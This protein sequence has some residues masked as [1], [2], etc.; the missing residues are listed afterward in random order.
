MKR[1]VRNLLAAAFAK[2]PRRP[3]A[4]LAFASAAT[5]APAQT[6]TRWDGNGHS[7]GVFAVKAG[8][9][10]EWAKRD[11]ESRGGHLATLTSAAENTF[12]TDLADDPEY[13]ISQYGS[14]NFGP[15][16]G[17]SRPDSSSGVND[18]RWVTG[19][20]FGYS[21]WQPLSGEPNNSGGREIYATFHSIGNTRSGYWN[22]LDPAYSIQPR[23]YVFETS[24]AVPEP[25]GLLA[26]GLAVGAMA[27][28]RRRAFWRKER[29]S[30]CGN[31]CAIHPSSSALDE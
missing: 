20:A 23:Y 18:W 14:W 9:G 26:L 31:G 30:F 28:G 27:R 11:A 7:Y 21:N 3:L 16:L 24:Q 12:V 10:W 8:E 22:D 5:F 15:Y 4:A 13:W 1:N 17:L 29:D 19:E 6:L 2:I 25:T